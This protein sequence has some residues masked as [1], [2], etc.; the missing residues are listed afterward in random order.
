MSF[1]QSKEVLWH[2][3]STKCNVLRLTRVRLVTVVD[4]AVRSLD[5]VALIWKPLRENAWKMCMTSAES[6][7]WR[8]AVNLL[9]GCWPRLSCPIA[10]YKFSSKFFCLTSVNLNQKENFNRKQYLL[11]TIS[12]PWCKKLDYLPCDWC[13]PSEEI[14]QMFQAPGLLN[15]AVI[16]YGLVLCWTQRMHFL[17]LPLENLPFSNFQLVRPCRGLR[18]FFLRWKDL[19]STPL[20][21]LRYS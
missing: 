4:G 8:V 6:I 2:I 20:R 16:P 3:I 15:T 18:R 10:T 12:S 14:V 9:K 21:S 5:L 13:T 11:Q 17:I 19:C 7:V 1:C